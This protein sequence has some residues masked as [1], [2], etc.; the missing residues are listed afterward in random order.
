MLDPFAMFAPGG[1]TVT[2]ATGTFE[3]VIA[4][5]P[6]FP[7]IVAVIVAVPAATAVNRPVLDT[8]ATA[9]LSLDHA[10]GRPVTGLLFA[11]RAAA[12]SWLVCPTVIVSGLGVT[13]TVATAPCVTVIVAASLLPSAVPVIVALPGATA[14][15]MPVASTVATPPLLL[16]QMTARSLSR[17]FA[18][19][20]AM[21]VSGVCAPGVASM[22]FGRTTTFATGVFCTVIAAMPDL[23]L[24]LAA[25]CVVPS[26]SP[27]TTPVL[28]TLAIAGSLT[29]HTTDAE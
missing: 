3:T 10:T 12:A 23:P 29:L 19:S 16:V 21:A 11:S 17:L 9:P 18:A 28:D 4:A 6:S 14:V 20:Y 15:T 8:L 5:V 25:I 13:A 24:A 26:A 1:C 2:L 7:S 22:W 27:V